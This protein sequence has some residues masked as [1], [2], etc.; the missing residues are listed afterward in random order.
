[1]TLFPLYV[2]LP[3]VS[4]RRG[5]I[6]PRDKCDVM[7]NTLSRSIPNKIKGVTTVTVKTRIIITEG[8]GDIC[9]DFLLFLLKC[10]KNY[11]DV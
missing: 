1:M 7:L 9:F 4:P 6:N 2:T 5:L 11:Y 10:Q 8:I 3:K